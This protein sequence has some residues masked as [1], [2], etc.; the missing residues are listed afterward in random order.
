MVKSFYIGIII[1]CCFPGRGQVFSFNSMNAMHTNQAI[2]SGCAD[3]AG[4]IYMGGDFSKIGADYYWGVAKWNGAQWDSLGSGF[5]VD[6]QSLN[7]SQ[8]ANALAFYNNEIYAGGSFTSVQGKSIRYIA[9]WNGTQ[10]DSLPQAPNADVTQLVVYNGKLYVLGEF[11]KIGTLSCNNIAVWDG[12][13]WTPIWP[14]YYSSG[15]S[16]MVEYKGELYLGGN[17]SASSVGGSIDLLKYVGG[18]WVPVGAGIKGNISYVTSLKVF[19]NDLYIGGVMK[20]AA[21]NAGDYLLKWD[22]SQFKEVIAG[23]D[24]E[25]KCLTVVP[26]GLIATG[27][28]TTP[29][30]K[31]M[32]ISDQGVCGYNDSISDCVE[33]AIYSANRLYIY[34]SFTTVQ[35][36]STLGFACNVSYTT[37]TDSCQAFSSGVSE[38]AKAGEVMLY[39]NPAMSGI[40]VVDER[41][42]FKG[43]IITLNNSVG[44]TVLQLSFQ[45]EIMLS[46]LPDG[47][48]TISIRCANGALYHSRFMK[49]L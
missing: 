28:F 2:R 46:A 24:G 37:Q 26:D 8:G 4:N 42:E 39:P 34:G 12:I 21:G 15:L 41:Q 38:W 9:R 31:M 1:C 14:Y 7:S 36:D 5:H 29:F 47:F 16:D 19:N 45:K 44:Q 33:G 35:G 13:S 22:G 30:S 49:Q 43:A 48:Y 27:C 17:I 3:N 25:V 32:K 18:N 40:T 6:G 23:I 20:K 11:S 10:W